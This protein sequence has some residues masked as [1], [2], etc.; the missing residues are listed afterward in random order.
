MQQK[1]L[2]RCDWASVMATEGV[3][4]RKN[5]NMML[6]MVTTPHSLTPPS[7]GFCRFCIT[8]NF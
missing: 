1:K 5:L 7:C 6:R 2:C 3:Y 4:D 8:E